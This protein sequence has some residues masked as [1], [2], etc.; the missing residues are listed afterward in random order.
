MSVDDKI[1]DFFVNMDK[2]DNTLMVNDGGQKIDLFKPVSAIPD[3]TKVKIKE[4]VNTVDA[5]ENLNDFLVQYGISRENQPHTYQ[6]ITDIWRQSGEPSI[7]TSPAKGLLM[8]VAESISGGEF[9]GSYNWFS[10]EIKTY[11]NEDIDIL[12]AELS[13]PYEMA[14]EKSGISG[15]AKT[16]AHA[17]YDFLYDL[18]KKDNRYKREG[19]MEHGV[20]EITEPK[21][22][23]NIRDALNMDF[24][25]KFGE[26]VDTEH[27]G[28]N[29]PYAGAWQN[30]QIINFMNKKIA[31]DS[32]DYETYRKDRYERMNENL[33]D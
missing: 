10:N 16:A 4:F 8:K 19:T 2:E 18:V 27:L 29:A 24:E 30:D 20:H 9:K 26:P 14:G 17:S 21:L 23:A 3:T 6:A 5:S 11:G 31:D 25:N 15:A 12:V 22:H 33:H 1:M 28:L 32:Y 13:H 7:N